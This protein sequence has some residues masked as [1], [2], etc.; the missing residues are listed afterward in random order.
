MKALTGI[1]AI[2]IAMFTL[3]AC[4]EFSTEP[5][6]LVS[7]TG[8]PAD[9]RATLDRRGVPTDPI[10]LG[11]TDVKLVVVG[12]NKL[13]CNWKWN[14]EPPPRFGI[15][16]WKGGFEPEP[17]F[18]VPGDQTTFEYAPWLWNQPTAQLAVGTQRIDSDGTI[19]WTH[20]TLSNEVTGP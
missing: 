4:G 17:E 1:L 11:F 5:E 6:A 2:L 7:P 8:T 18:T 9:T 16:V 10:I 20:V 13:K 3:A 19:R 14:G 12:E 15:F